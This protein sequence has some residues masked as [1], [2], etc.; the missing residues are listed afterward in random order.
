MKSIILT[1]HAQDRIAERSIK[2]NDVIEAIKNPDVTCPTRNK[3]RKRIMKTLN[4]KTL[5]VIIEE[6]DKCIL[7]VTCAMLEKEAKNGN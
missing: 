2:K 6:R 3:R 7:V 1:P 4:N 5:D